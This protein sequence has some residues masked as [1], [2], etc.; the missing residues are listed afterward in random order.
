MAER[1]SGYVTGGISPFGQL[2]SL[3]TFLD[4][5]AMTLESMLVSAG[6]RGLQLELRPDVLVQVA[7]ARPVEGLGVPG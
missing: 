7:A 1:I 6:Q 2:R 5:S 4:H 3:P